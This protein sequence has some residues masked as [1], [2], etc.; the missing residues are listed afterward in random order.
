MQEYYKEID[1][2]HKNHG[3]DL[4]TFTRRA[5]LKYYRMLYCIYMLVKCNL[6]VYDF[7][8]GG[9]RTQ[10][11]LDQAV[12]LME[13]TQKHLDAFTEEQDDAVLDAN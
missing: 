7:A 8:P 3:Y 6:T 5:L 2:I 13:R 4:A 9:A 11:L 10:E 12:D 1:D